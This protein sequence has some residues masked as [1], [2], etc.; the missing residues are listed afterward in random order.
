VRVA[1]FDC[2]SGISGGMALSALVDAGAD[3]KVI[4][5]TLAALPIGEFTLER[6]QMDVQGMAASRIRLEAA[7]Q[8][9]IR[10]YASIRAMLQVEALPGEVAQMAQRIYRRLAEAAARV[11]GKEVEFVTF[12]EFGPVDC[13]VDI[14]GCSLALHLLAVERVFASPI[15]TGMGMVRTE[16]G[17]M[18]VPGP[19]VMELLQ[20]APTYSR[21]IPVE[22]VTPS[23]AAILASISEGYGDMPMMRAESVG[24]GAGEL[25]LDFP[26]VVRVVIGTSH[27]VAGGAQG[28]APS[29]LV[30]QATAEDLSTRESGR[31]VDRLIRA[32]ATDA[33]VTQAVG[34]GGRRRSIVSAVAAPKLAEDL[35]RTLASEPSVSDVRALPVSIRRE[36][37][38]D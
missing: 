34:P 37:Q 8:E 1:Y 6:E 15:P 12:H 18:P 31:L 3:L 26:H 4:A 35:V 28:G 33:W 7:P 22:L 5:D 21:G 14:V 16:H 36:S 17:L 38:P 30:I 23:G 25:R 9:V 10:T 20:G 24:Y 2:F 11:H 32:G 27:R 29:E 13:L 19:V